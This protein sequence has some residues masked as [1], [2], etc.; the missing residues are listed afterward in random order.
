VPALPAT[1]AAPA[2]QPDQPAI[3]SAAAL[4][5][6]PAASRPARPAAMPAVPLDPA[7]VR[8][9][10]RSRPPP[11][12]GDGFL[13][14]VAGELVNGFGD[15]PNGQRNDGVNIAAPAGAPVRAAEH[16]IVVYA[17]DGVAGF[18]NMVLLRHAD[19]FTTAYAHADRLEVKVGDVVRRGQVVAR[20]G[21]TGV[22]ASPQLHFELRSG[23]T[24]LDPQK[25]L[26]GKAAVLAGD[27]SGASQYSDPNGRF[28]SVRI[29]AP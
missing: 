11:L 7:I 5:T 18:G 12:S 16:G 23:K 2:P 20:V 4:A 28:T 10:V 3:G 22:V 9:A 25:H 24:P 27:A 6:P 17:G 26:T 1:R 14:P 15:K 21:A 29:G 13:L 19:G 8:R